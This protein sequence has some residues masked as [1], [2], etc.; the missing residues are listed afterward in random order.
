MARNLSIGMTGD[1]VRS[2]QFA[3]NY[4]LRGLGLPD[5][6][7]DGKFG[8]KTKASVLRAQKIAALVPDGVVGPKTTM[9][10][11]NIGGITASVGVEPG[12]FSG[13][14]PGSSLGVIASSLPLR[15]RIKIP[16]SQLTQGAI[17]APPGA[18]PPPGPAPTPSLPPVTVQTVIVLA[19]NQF[20]VS[21]TAFTPFVAASQ[22]NILFKLGPLPPFVL[23]PGAQF[24]ANSV[25]SPNGKYTGQGF[26][27][28]GPPNPLFS[29]GSIDFL[30]PFI[31]GFLQKNAGQPSQ[32]GFAVGNQVTWKIFGD[33]LGVF[34]NTQAVFA[35]DIHSGAGQPVS[36]QALGGLQLDLVKLLQRF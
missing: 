2:L 34:V 11:L 12:A 17:T 18:P 32:E 9:A 5:L 1:D 8:E 22:I 19:G 33:T 28:L 14:T 6:T 35:W 26:V 23:S 16:M 31:Q 27:Q 21:P 20:S 24:S 15:S 3:L 30:N 25:G 36:F 13:G 29:S 10:L 7:A 4:H